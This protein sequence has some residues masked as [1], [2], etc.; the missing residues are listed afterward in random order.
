MFVQAWGHYGTAWPVVHQQL[1]VRPDM[2]RRELEVTPQVPPGQSRLAGRDIRLGQGSID[3]AASAREGSRYRTAV[4]VDVGLSQLV[5]GHTLPRGAR[6]SSVT[7][8]GEPAEYASG[9]PT[10]GAR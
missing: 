9:A 7:L 5:L 6:V 8:D 4:D 2:G 3:A 10:A 1:G